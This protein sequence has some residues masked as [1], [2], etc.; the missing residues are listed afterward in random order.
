M[1]TFASPALLWLALSLVPVV[2]LYLLR[3]RF[4]RRPSGSNFL[5]NRVA[6]RAPG[7]SRP[8]LRSLLLLAL[9]VGAALC[10]VLAAAG[11]AIVQHGSREPGLAILVDVSAS[12]ATEDMTDAAGFPE[13]RVAAAAVAARGLIEGLAPG[14]PAEVFACSAGLRSLAGPDAG[15]GRVLAALNDLAPTDSGFRELAV[16]D[17]FAAWL[18]SRGG[19][20]EAVLLTDGGLDAGGSRLAAVAGTLRI[21]TLGGTGRGGGVADLRIGDGGRSGPPAAAAGVRTA[22]TKRSASFRAFNGG[23]SAFSATARLERDGDL[24]AEAALVLE[25]GWS[26]HELAFPAGSLDGGYELSLIA[27]GEAF[28]RTW[29]SIHAAPPRRVLLVGRDDPYLRAA[30]AYPGIELFSSAEFPGPKVLSTLD[31]VVAEGVRAPAGLACPLLSI[32]AL[33]TADGRGGGSGP[34]PG[35]LASGPLAT[36]AGSHP[37]ARFVAWEGAS[38]A[39]SLSILPVPG[40]SALATAGDKTVAAAWTEEGFPRAFLGFDPARSDFGLSPAWPIFMANLLDWC[41]PREGPQSAYSLEAGSVAQ[42]AIPAGFRIEGRLAPAVTRRGRSSLLE[43]GRAGLYR[44]SAE[45]DSGWLAVN[46]PAE[47]LDVSPRSL[48][49]PARRPLPLAAREPSRRDLSFIPLAGLLAFLVAEWLVWR[50]LPTRILAG[51]H[52][53]RR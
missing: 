36:V 5:W 33:P 4:R 50:G 13:S 43:T 49:V 12:M 23:A 27:G 22:T 19:A 42:R 47:E 39:E 48:A 9:Q 34:A 17:A 6:G 30:L 18:A 45:G 3:R 52:D 11:P 53:A 15:R 38:V 51:R 32:A 14:R 20:W 25:P 7:S 28:G 37:L 41:A 26:A 44:W 40:T 46:P 16:A 35:P 24:L 2:A 21:E 1:L 31:L 10:A 8:E 29:L